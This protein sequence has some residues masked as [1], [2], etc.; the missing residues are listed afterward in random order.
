VAGLKSS[1]INLSLINVFAALALTAGVPCWGE[2]EEAIPVSIY[3][4]KEDPNWPAAEKVLVE[5]ARE[6]PRLR[7]TKIAIDDEAG[8][9]QLAEAEKT[10]GINPTGEITV[11]IGPLFLTSQGERR[12]V[13]T[14]FSSLT[15][16]VLHPEGKKGR[17]PCD[18]KAFA[19]EIFGKGIQLQPAEKK[20][21]EQN[22]VFNAVLQNGKMAGWVVE[23][24]RH[25]E[26]PSCNDTQFLLALKMPEETIAALRPVQDLER[27][28]LKLSEKETA[29]FLG[30]FNGRTLAQQDQKIDYIPNAAK[31]SRSYETAV[32]EVMRELAKLV[33]GGK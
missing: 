5:V 3:Y 25:I 26:C 17:L 11:T 22:T 32:N 28:G 8:Y 18:A 9:K 30:Q 10:L 23:V 31:T 14:Y 21:E 19:A 16:Q 13:E 20:A 24:Y 7:L 33:G 29:A 1:I 12:D 15:R 27:W 6:N 4:S 2:E